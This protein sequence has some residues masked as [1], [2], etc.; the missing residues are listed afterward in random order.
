MNK[1]KQDFPLR[2]SAGLKPE[3]SWFSIQAKANT[4]CTMKSAVGALLLNSLPK[5]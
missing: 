2:A 5:S 4:L 1:S 3:N